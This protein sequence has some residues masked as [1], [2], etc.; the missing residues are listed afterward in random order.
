MQVRAGVS[1]VL[2]TPHESQT[3]YPRMAGRPLHCETTVARWKLSSHCVRNP[4][5]QTLHAWVLALPS[6][7]TPERLQSLFHVWMT[8]QMSGY[9]PPTGRER[10]CLKLGPSVLRPLFFTDVVSCLVSAAISL[11]KRVP[12]AGELV[13]R[14]KE[15]ESG[16]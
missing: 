12:G 15:H 7:P 11:L 4:S 2:L 8:L 13:P 10:G 16:M 14:T 6:G 1:H 3:P 9:Q 5:P